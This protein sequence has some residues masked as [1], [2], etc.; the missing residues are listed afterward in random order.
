MFSR[1]KKKGSVTKTVAKPATITLIQPESRPQIKPTIDLATAK[2]TVFKPEE[3][4]KIMVKEG[5]EDN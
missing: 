1:S 2:I 5:E 3:G 4:F